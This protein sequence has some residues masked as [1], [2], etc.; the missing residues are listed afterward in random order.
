MIDQREL[1]EALAAL[2]TRRR[3]MATGTVFVVVTVQ[4]PWWR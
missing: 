3:V 4:L 1:D 2:V